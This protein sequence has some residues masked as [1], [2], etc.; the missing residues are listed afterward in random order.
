MTG[1][2]DHKNTRDLHNFDDIPEYSYYFVD[3]PL[4]LRVKVSCVIHGSF[5]MLNNSI[6]FVKSQF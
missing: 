3:S 4:S 1:K 2:A 6:I 5:E